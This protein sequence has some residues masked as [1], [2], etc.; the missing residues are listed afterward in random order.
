MVEHKRETPRDGRRDF[1]L[2]ARLEVSR[3]AVCM[4]RH[5]IKHVE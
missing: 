3:E 1:Y 4:K 5:L 2:A